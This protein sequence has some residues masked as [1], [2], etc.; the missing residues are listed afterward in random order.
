MCWYSTKAQFHRS[1]LNNFRWNTNDMH[2]KMDVYTCAIDAILVN[3]G[4]AL[5]KRESASLRHLPRLCQQVSVLIP[6]KKLFRN[7]EHVARKGPAEPAPSEQ[8]F[9]VWMFA[10]VTTKVSCALRQCILPNSSKV[11]MF[12]NFI[13]K[14]F[15]FNLRYYPRYTKRLE[16]WYPSGILALRYQSS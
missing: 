7:C 6:K 9:F 11:P 14:I 15:W 8:C 13:Q 10:W 2:G 5:Y 12:H 16:L 1:Y 3:L 4:K